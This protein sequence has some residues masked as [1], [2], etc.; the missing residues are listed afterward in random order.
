MMRLYAMMVFALISTV[1]MG[2][3]SPPGNDRRG[4]SSTVIST[5]DFA[6]PAA[7]GDPNGPHA[8]SEVLSPYEPVVGLTGKITS[9]GDSTTTNLVARIAAE[10]RR[11]YPDVT[12]QVT[13]SPINIGPAALLDTRVDFVPM[14][15]PLAPEEIQEFAAKYGYPPTEIKVAADALA[16]YVEKGNP[17]S[18]LSLEQLD[19]I[20]S[21]TQRRGLSSIETWGQVGL[22]AEWAERRI[23]LYGY[24]PYDGAHQIFQQRVLNG[25]VFRLSLRVEGG[26]SS[27]VQGVASDPGA[28]GFAS[29]FFTCKRVRI[30]PL[31]GADGQ[32]YTPTEENVRRQ[33]YPLGRFLYICVNKPPRQP[34]SGP[35]AEYLRF[36]L[37]RDGQQIVAAGG[38]IPLD[39]ATVELGRRALAE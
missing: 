18:G 19:A 31:A 35:V 28:I 1:M 5:T 8:I 32:F 14:S 6:V 21:Q 13:S 34:L 26:G 37:S 29:V 12:L 15:R 27:I 36:L 38:N 22:T 16:V 39:A 7:E 25:G 4:A 3:S 2:C 30:V 9:I 33:K 24:G 10:F 23:T 17:V 11:M 20:F